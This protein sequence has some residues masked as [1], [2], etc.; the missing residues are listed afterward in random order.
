M[1]NRIWI[2]GGGWQG[3]E[4]ETKSTNGLTESKNAESGAPPMGGIQV[5]GQFLIR[6][7]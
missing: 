1:R 5:V 3:G 7:N 2:F 4:E 6:P